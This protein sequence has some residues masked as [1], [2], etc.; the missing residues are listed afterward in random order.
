MQEEFGFNNILV[1]HEEGTVNND[2]LTQ[3]LQHLEEVEARVKWEDV[4]CRSGAEFG[5]NAFGWEPVNSQYLPVDGILESNESIATNE[6][7][8]SLTLSAAGVDFCA[9][10]EAYPFQHFQYFAHGFQSD[11]AFTTPQMGWHVNCCDSP[12]QPDNTY[13]ELSPSASPSQ[14]VN[15]TKNPGFSEKEIPVAAIP[16]DAASVDQVDYFP[17]AVAQIFVS[18]ISAFF[19]LAT[20]LAMTLPLLKKRRRKR[21]STYNLYL[22]FLAIPDLIYNLFLVYL[23][24]TYEQWLAYIVPGN[25]PWIDHPFDLAL[26]ATCAAA[27][28]YMNAIIA[29][30]ILKLLRNSKRRKRSKAPS[31]KKASFQAL[32]TYTV[33]A[34]IFTVDYFGDGIAEVLPNS[35]IACFYFPL[36]I[37]IPIAILLWV[38]LRIYWEKLIGDVRTKAGKRLTIL[39]RYF[40]RIIVVYICIWLPASILYTAQFIG[41][42]QKGSLYYVACILYALAAWANFVLSLT[43][44]DVRRNFYEL[45]TGKAFLPDP[46]KEETN[47]FTNSGISNNENKPKEK[48]GTTST[49]EESAGIAPPIEPDV[50]K[51]ISK[52]AK[53]SVKI[54]IIGMKTVLKSESSAT[55]GD[56]NDFDF[57]GKDAPQARPQSMQP[58]E[59]K[60]SM[61]GGV[62]GRR[63]T[64]RRNSVCSADARNMRSSFNDSLRASPG[65]SS[66]ANTAVFRSSLVRRHSEHGVMMSEPFEISTA[67]FSGRSS[68]LDRPRERSNSSDEKGGD[69]FCIDSGRA[70]DDLVDL[71]KP[72]SMVLEGEEQ[73]KEINNARLPSALVNNVGES[74]SRN[75]RTMSFFMMDRSSELERRSAT[76]AF[77]LDDSNRTRQSTLTSPIER[78]K[79]MIGMKKNISDLKNLLK[80]SDV[81]EQQKKVYTQSIY[82]NKKALNSV[83]SVSVY[84]SPQTSTRGVRFSS[85][86]INIEGVDISDTSD[87]TNDF[88]SEELND[89]EGD[90]DSINGGDPNQTSSEL[91]YS[92]T[93]W[94]S[95]LRLNI[96]DLNL[97][98]AEKNLDESEKE[99]ISR[100]I[101]T[102]KLTLESIE[103]IDE[104]ADAGMLTSISHHAEPIGANSRLASNLEVILDEE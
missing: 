9:D 103:G 48:R 67:E 68:F 15:I 72:P 77:F 38:C 73:D 17:F 1:G 41:E 87:L 84:M 61:F 22:V 99:L 56:V 21:A 85:D 2:E 14:M 54:S 5:S 89:D 27:N 93:R 60:T 75:T 88:S 4:H 62:L 8:L 58:T 94:L 86:S 70:I 49:G 63:F 29:M 46:K 28:L 11:D 18:S 80:K 25:V 81:S 19:S 33:G 51:G 36:T 69:K 65:D 64:A 79:W 13:L 76:T 42:E 34:T 71:K 83:R 59:Q 10:N 82:L 31:L 52:P 20:I 101:E 50:E 47:Q 23:F 97:R 24:A 78:N 35:V 6:S 66:F 90:E 55:E 57:A 32:A 37:G 3:N 53:K 7:L 12:Q 98:L 45:F 40:T 96:R 39:I 16:V 104:E 44:P 43:K 100:A 91:R 74:T 102:Q 26:F 30:E 95:E 92:R